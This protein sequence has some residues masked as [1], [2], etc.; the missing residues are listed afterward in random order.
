MGGSRNQSPAIV[1]RARP[2]AAAF[3]AAL[4][5]PDG[6]PLTLDPWQARYLADDAKIVS[7]VKSRRVGGSWI[8]ALKM[9]CRAMLTPGYHGVFVSMNREEARGKID[10]CENFHDAL[11][12]RWRLK[13][14][15]RSRDEIA[16]VDRGGRRS[17][18][19]S[20]A[21][22]APRGRG[23]DVG[24]SELPHCLH[25]RSI[26]DGALH[27]TARRMEDIL[28]VESTPLG[29]DGIFYELSRGA[30]EKVVRYE[31]PW[32][33]SRGLCVDVD[34][35]SAEAPAMTTSRRVARFGSE[36]LKT[37][38]AAMAE[39]GFRQESE[40]YF[41]DVE[42]AVFPAALVLACAETDFA[43]TGAA[44][45][46]RRVDAIPSAA[47]WRWLES[48]R[49]GRLVAGY[50]PARTRDGAALLILDRVG[51]RRS[52][53]MMVTLRETPF[54]RQREVIEAALAHGV[55]ALAVDA[56]GVGMNLAETLATRFPSRVKPVTFTPTSKERMIGALHAAFTGKKIA[57]PADRDLVAE[58]AALRERVTAAGNRVYYAPRSA[59]A[60][61]D[62][63]W[64]LALAVGAD[65]EAN[66]GR[67]AY[68]SLSRRSN[69]NRW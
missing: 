38:Y 53:R 36:S 64:G 46:F 10:Y 11:P 8:M 20:L 43:P 29:N 15:A 5:A 28:T 21:G 49:S 27:V 37:I 48:A 60:H 68:E 35:A 34:K 16:F 39:K 23:G 42:E 2:T 18:L 4:V 69:R 3:A 54:D 12:P 19:R 7:I 52:V 14:T 61:A 22:K 41:S 57:L 67:P 65:D 50:D 9:F 32:W 24:V 56:T 58:L 40:L 30:F 44:Y 17:A 6:R 33:L 45:A 13:V 47:D 1:V 51:E 62:R 25:A 59:A 55:A 63:A 26:Y 31:V 66:A